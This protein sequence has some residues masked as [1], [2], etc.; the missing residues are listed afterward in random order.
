MFGRN[1]IYVR[2]I[3]CSYNK[4]IRLL[5]KEAFFVQNGKYVMQVRAFERYI[6]LTCIY[7]VNVVVRTMDMTGSHVF[8]KSMGIMLINNLVLPLT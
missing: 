5:D 4:C 1:V 8:C 2:C 6:P 7:V 3:K